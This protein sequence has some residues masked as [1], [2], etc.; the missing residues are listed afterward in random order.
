MLMLL[1][2]SG[3]KVF[4]YI[5]I[6]DGIEAVI[7]YTQEIE[8]I[9]SSFDFEIDGLVIKI[10]NIAL[11]QRIGETG[12]HP[13]WA[14]SYKFKAE[15]K[16]TTLNDV[17]FTV[18]RTGYIGIVGLIEPVILSGAKIARVSLHN[19][20]WIE[21][22]DIRI[23]DQVEA[24]RAGEVIPEIIRSLTE[25]RT[26]SEKKIHPPKKCPSCQEPVV[27]LDYEQVAYYCININC[28]AQIKERLCHF[29]AKD[30]MNI[31]GLGESII[32]LFYEK[33]FI[34]KFADIYRLKNYREEILE[35]DGFQEKRVD[36]ILNAIEASKRNDLHRLIYALGIRHIGE[37]SAKVLCRSFDSIDKILSASYEELLNMD[38]FGGKM[39]D[40]LYKYLREN[41]KTILELRE[42]GLNLVSKLASQQA[43]KLSGKT[44]LFTGELNLMGRREAK[45]LVEKN[46]GIILS[47]VSKNLDYLIVGGSPGSKLKKAQELGVKVLNEEEFKGMVS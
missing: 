12:H 31:D 41:E 37:K 7:R 6:V 16:I 42:L 34:K 36:N 40:S 35:L 25:K 20:S 45:E 28:P 10:N 1:K 47:A 11:Q 17:E 30:M 21:E 15:T 33:G 14:I 29:S 5:K 26:G 23:G 38:E 44:F 27:K 13:R 9:K 46:G 4:E 22:K 18:G 39:A 2:A 8:K 43:G 19:F 32:E 3:L 24:K